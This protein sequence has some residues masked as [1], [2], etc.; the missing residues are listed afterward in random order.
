MTLL[1]ISNSTA[2]G[3]G[4]LDHAEPEIRRVLDG[5]RTVL[6]VPFALHDRQAYAAKA[7]DRFAKMGLQLQSIH[8]QPDPVAAVEQAEA[9]FI[10]GGNTFRLLNELHR[11]ASSLPSARASPRGCP[12]WAPAPARTSPAP[13]S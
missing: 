5:V 13:P 2:F 4:Y 9:I 1:L 7:R 3:G 6:F 8:E 12:T 10:G 11:A